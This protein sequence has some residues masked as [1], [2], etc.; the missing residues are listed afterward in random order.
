MRRQRRARKSGAQAEKQELY[1]RLVAQGI[2]N[3]EACRVVGIN[4]KTGNRWRYGR[5]IRNTAGE[6]VQYPPVKIA[7]SRPRSPRYLSE[8]ERVVIADRLT[9]GTSIRAI[10]TEIGRSASTV[11]REIKRNSD[12]GGRYRPHRAEHAARARAARPR[13]RRIAQDAI[14]RE[15]VT[16][17]LLKRWSPEQVAHELQVRFA[18]QPRRWLCTESI[19]QAIYDPAVEVTR[20]ARRRRRRRRLL[21]IQRRG[22]LTAMRMLD[23]R[24]MEAL[25]RV[26]GGHWEGDLIMG[27][28]NRS[29]IG[30]LV[31]RTTRFVVLLHLPGGI[32]TADAVRQAVTSALMMLPGGLRRTLTWDQGKE[33]ALHQQITAQAGVGVFFC[34]AHSPWQRGSNENTNGLLR[35][36][37]PKGTD[38]ALIDARELRR[39]AD[40]LNDR[41]RKTLGWDRPS[42]L[43]QSALAAA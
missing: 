15:A 10:A 16:G 13:E 25:D 37:F 19:Y 17:L 5:S 38:L 24:P 6:L 41:P 22:R 3:S 36:Y 40:E 30:T 2:N 4:R 20:P 8:H 32:G 34:D 28:G 43:F 27:P 9:A 39:V 29:A 35:D 18:G 23:E 26:Q 11:S 42:D 12:P 1:G 14:L 31:E 33:L 21:G 7:V